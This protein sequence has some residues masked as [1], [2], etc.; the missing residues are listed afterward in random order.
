MA[1]IIKK[2]ESNLELAKDLRQRG[3]IITPRQL[4]QESQ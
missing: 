4:F 2:E 3:V 1:F